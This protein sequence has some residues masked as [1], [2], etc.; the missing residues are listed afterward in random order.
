MGEWMNQNLA[1]VYSVA[2]LVILVALYLAL[3]FKI[4]FWW[5]NFWYSL[6]LVGKLARLSRDSTLH[7]R[8]PGW[9]NVE[10]TLCEDYRGFMH[11]MSP[12]E[13]ERRLTYLGKA[14]DIGRSH[15][16]GWLLGLLAFL[17]IAEGLG[18]SY[19]LG[20]WMA[21][22]GSEN[23]RVLLMGAIVFVLCTILLFIMHSAGHQLYRTSLI[24]RCNKEWRDSGQ[25]KQF[26]TGMINLKDDQ[27]KD[28]R[29]PEYTQCVN[30]VGR[31]GSI[32]MVI[33]AVISIVIIA[34]FSTWMRVEHLQR[35][36]TSE[37]LLMDSPSESQAGNPFGK[38][39]SDISKP[40][41]PDAVS[42]PQEDADKKGKKDLDSNEFA[43]GMA[44][45]LLLAF[46]FIATQIVAIATGFKWS[47]AGRESKAAYDGTMGFALY[48][49]YER[50]FEPVRQS[51][52]AKLQTLQ[53]TLAEQ[54]T[55]QARGKYKH[56]FTDYLR[57]PRESLRTDVPAFTPAAV[58]E[59]TVATPQSGSATA[60]EPEMS[61]RVAEA[62]AH[63]D[64]LTGKDGK[65]DF[66]TSLE[67]VLQN[68]V[69]EVIRERKKRE[70]QARKNI[71]DLLD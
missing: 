47:F 20:T 57:E 62:I 70:Q 28:D 40:V 46:I 14:Q 71:E 19:L 5:L 12:A 31:D 18:F 54:D 39:A 22:E 33:I 61:A 17:V 7:A 27:T 65:R 21:L 3:K 37:S 50:H 35:V 29:E 41:L 64:S 48:D 24:K 9:T 10:R 59:R 60:P 16:P 49:D 38:K 30:R 34:T 32:A 8:A 52:Q 15:V 6:P 67:L 2:S 4:D 26:S 58:S 69:A 56:T 63:F 36:Q 25:E 13:F 51:A 11:F 23:I 68:K 43:E 44:A 1:A 45:F 55:N 53:Q 66:L 42:N